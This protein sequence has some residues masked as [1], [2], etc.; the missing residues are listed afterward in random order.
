MKKNTKKK[1]SRQPKSKGDSMNLNNVK[2]LV[3]LIEKSTVNEIEVEE[4]GQ[5]I[6]I[7]KNAAGG[8]AVHGMMPQFP[9]HVMMPAIQ[10]MAS[11]SAV[12]DPAAP[13]QA[14]EAVDDKKYHEVKSPIVGTFYRAPS[15]EAGSYVEVGSS[16]NQGTVLCIVEAMKLMNE[17]ESDVSGTIA[18][19]LVENGK[20][21]EY[22]QTLFLVEQ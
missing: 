8:Q 5:R 19:I 7:T 21:V 22:G 18:K 13:P 12:V 16:V 14:P 1:I 6:R 3:E 15:P 2:Q 20:P 9:H 4:K 17:I 10:Q 11:A